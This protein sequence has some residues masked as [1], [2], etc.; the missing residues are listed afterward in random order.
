MGSEK[1]CF[2]IMPFSQTSDVHTGNYWDTFF[3]SFI[4]P[5]I[6]KVGYTCKRSSAE[7]GNIIKG[8]VYEL[9]NSDITL[10]YLFKLLRIV[11]Y[12]SSILSSF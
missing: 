7:P 5:N 6:E 8:V 1:H 10:G 3:F 4:K 2:V 9:I 12:S 11:S